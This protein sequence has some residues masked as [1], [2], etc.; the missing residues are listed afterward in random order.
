MPN[1]ASAKKR[2]KQIKKRNL[3]N[4]SRKS[5]VK[6]SVKKVLKALENKEVEH[7]KEFLVQAESNIA[8]AGQKGVLHKNT[9]S[10]LISRLARRVSQQARS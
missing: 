2:E 7:A 10:R 9:M 4:T 6:T 8:R 5:A 3:L 1:I